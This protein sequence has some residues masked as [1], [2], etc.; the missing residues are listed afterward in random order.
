M[1]IRTIHC[2]NCGYA[3]PDST[4]PNE[5]VYCSACNST[6]FI[7]D[8]KVGDANQK[9]VVT[10]PARI[11]TVGSLLSRDDLCNVYQCAFEDQQQTWQGMFRLA[12]DPADND[13]VRNEAQILSHFQAT[14]NYGDYRAF[15]PL[16][17]ESFVY[18]DAGLDRG[19]QVN[20]VT[21][22]E[23]VASPRDL[24]NFEEVRAYHATGIHPKD[25]AW[26]WRRLLFAL[27]FFHSHHVIHGAV[28]PSHVLIEPR[29][30]KLALTGWGFA[31]REPARTGR[32]LSAISM[33][34]ESW[35][36]AEVFAKAVPDAGL[37]LLTAARCMFYLMGGDPLGDPPGVLEPELQ[38]YFARFIEPNPKSRPQDA[39]A[40]LDDF[41]RIIEALWGPRTFREFKMPYKGQ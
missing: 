10:T 17:L 38:D 24:Y 36:P 19:A 20:I 9:V 33:P 6:L 39:W 3:L 23:H 40:A 34:Y 28:L 35:Y 5:L 1:T 4:R 26:M 41:D 15:L 18:Q 21:L 31:L 37:D 27:G 8:W 25:M 14:T 30:H 11:Y 22:H 13:L 16:L 7:S 12:R 32:H 29:E 2:P